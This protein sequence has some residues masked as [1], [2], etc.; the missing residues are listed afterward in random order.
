MLFS[1]LK[2]WPEKIIGQ[3]Y[4]QKKKKELEFNYFVVERDNDC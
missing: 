2:I 4:L 1:Q 3:N